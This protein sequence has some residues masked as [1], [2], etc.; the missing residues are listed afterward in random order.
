MIELP[1]NPLG[2][3]PPGWP[4]ILGCILVPLLRGSWR[5][6]YLLILPTLGFLQLLQIPDGS[7]LAIEF[8]PYTLDL[9]RVDALS[10]A[11]GLV[12]YFAAIVSTIFAMKV[13][14]ATQGASALLYAGSAIA[15]VFA[16]DLLTLFICWEL[17]AISSVF[18]IWANGN[19]D[20]GMRYLVIQVASGVLLLAGTIL[21]F[22]DTGSLDFQQM[23]LSGLAA[24]L[25]FLAFG[26]KAAFPLLHNWLQ[27]AYPKATPTG[28]VYLSAFTT[29]LAIYAL[30]RGFAGTEVL[31]PIG[32]VM[33]VFPLV[34]AAIEDDLRKVLAYALNNQLGFMVVGIGIGTELSLN[35]TVAHV[36]AHVAYKSL[37]FMCMGAVLFR[38]GTARASELGGLHRS[39]PWTAG[40]CIVAAASISMPLTGGFVAKSMILSAAAIEHHTAVYLALTGAAA[41]VF[42]FTGIRIPYLVFFSRDRGIR[43]QE[44]PLNMRVAM[45]VMAAVCIGIGVFPGVVYALLPFPVDY[46]PYTVSHVVATLQLLLFSVLAYFVFLRTGFL[47]ATVRG[48]LLDSDWVYRRA[49]PE[50]G[51]YAS[52]VVVGPFQ[53]LVARV[54]LRRRRAL[55]RLEHLL[56]PLG[57]LGEPWPTGATA[58]WAAILLFGTLLLSY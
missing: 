40:F 55:W 37:L 21:Y 56:R 23:D 9:I 6:A 12:F 32:T 58:L 30:A 31:I 28:A 57:R 52:N 16:G 34:Y 25:I 42:C 5:Q 1:V 54:D 44:A 38:T 43:V 4:M 2:S 53:R 22:A 27:D 13:D 19:V 17:T 39:M 45:S 24:W 41:G 46:V 33:A 36:F 10:R 35:G 26:I 8:A 11:F 3:L 7:S 20:T 47:P 50:L 48:T 14:D 15:A 49:L 51:R 18:L 29:K